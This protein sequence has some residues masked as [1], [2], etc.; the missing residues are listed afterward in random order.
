MTVFWILVINGLK[1]K[2]Y[3]GFQKMYTKLDSV[4]KCGKGFLKANDELRMMNDEKEPGSLRSL[5]ELW[6][7]VNCHLSLVIGC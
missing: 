1:K 7:T 3:Q 4:K 2:L 6:R 5:G